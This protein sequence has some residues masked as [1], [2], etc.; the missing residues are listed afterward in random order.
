[1]TPWLALLRLLALALPTWAGNV[2]RCQSYEE[3]TLG[4]LQTLCSD[5]SRATSTWNRT[6]GPWERPVTPPPSSH[7]GKIRPQPKAPRR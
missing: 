7:G 2:V 4:R 6:L 1:M 5:G 3:R